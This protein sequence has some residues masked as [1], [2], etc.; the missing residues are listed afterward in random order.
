MDRGSNE[1]LSIRIGKAHR[2]WVELDEAARLLEAT[3]SAVFSQRV[4]AL[5]DM[6]VSRA[7]N[8]V[9]ASE[10]WSD[11]VGKIEKARTAANHARVDWKY[12]E[13]CLVEWQSSA[14]DERLRAKL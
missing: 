3:K 5:G 1:P 12:L 10:F 6:P 4:I 14:A 11:H 8:M 2:K 7:E 13:N 9:R